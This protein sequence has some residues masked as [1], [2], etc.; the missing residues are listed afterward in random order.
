MIVSKEHVQQSK[1]S[2]V[3]IGRFLMKKNLNFNAMQT[4]LSSIWRPKEGME[5]HDIG[6][7]R[8]SFIFYHPLDVQKVVEGGPW[9]F[10]QGMLVFK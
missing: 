4:V 3:L 10:E 2:F 8:Y 7:M 9:S 5:I 6:E 1:E